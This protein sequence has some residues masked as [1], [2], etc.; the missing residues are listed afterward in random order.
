MDLAQVWQTLI[1][2]LLA[3]VATAQT[4]PYRLMVRLP[5][6]A[7]TSFTVQQPQAFLSARS[8]ARRAKFSIPIR[9]RDLPVSA[10]YL[11]QLSGLGLSVE[12]SSKWL[13]AV[14]V[15]GDSAF[16]AQKLT[17]L[18][19]GGTAPKVQVSRALGPSK[20]VELCD[21]TAGT[22]TSLNYGIGTSQARM[23]GIDS[24][25][26]RGFTGRGVMVAVMDAGFQIVDRHIAFRHMIDS[27]RL[28]DTR[29]YVFGQGNSVFGVH[30]HGGAAYGCI[31]GYMP[32]SFIGGAYQADYAFYITE[33][34]RSEAPIEM[35]N[36][37]VAAERADSLG[38]DLINTSLGYYTFDKPWL[39]FS[40][41]QMTGQV[42]FLADALDY[43]TETGIVCVTSAGNEGGN[44]TWGG[45]ITTPADAR[46]GIAVG[47]VGPDSALVNFSGRGL[48]RSNNIKPD[49][50]AQGIR[51]ALY[52]WNNPAGAGGGGAGTSFS[53]PLVSGLLAGM[54]QQFPNV[55]PS[56]W[57]EA[58]RATSN[59]A[60]RP[61]T[62]LG[63][64]IPNYGRLARYLSRLTDTNAPVTLQ[65]RVYPNPA[66]VGQPTVIQM[67]AGFKIQQIVLTDVLG[68]VV[69]TYGPAT[70][71]PS[72]ASLQLGT[73]PAGSYG[74]Q[75]ITPQ[76]AVRGRL[77]VAKH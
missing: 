20:H 9:E 8:L 73:L 59:N 46:L 24:M 50:V 37:V 75:I 67:A 56:Q 47:A 45:K 28:A 10:V 33:D 53:A 6:K 35:F 13:N 36:W 49:V 4:Q 3:S 1:C 48:G 43:A 60:A 69:G 68:R 16:I 66:L 19:W 42:S 57:L 30:W 12:K 11:Q 72:M 77:V 44:P 61:D 31:G 15:A 21:N 41:E 2:L 14:V 65:A 62:L 52:D 5:D 25:H 70:G 74:Y 76:G 7:G 54:M 71:Q 58:L 38:V 29:D 40:P 32:G 63:Y 64:G 22:S 39:N 18:S 27:G 55:K 34:I 23:L 51:V 17:Q 26:A